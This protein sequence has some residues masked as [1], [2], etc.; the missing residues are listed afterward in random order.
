MHIDNVIVIIIIAEKLWQKCGQKS[1]NKQTVKWEK[2]YANF[3]LLLLQKYLY[4]ARKS[5]LKPGKP[6]VLRYFWG[7]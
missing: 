5:G 2:N 1:S 7:I 3:E 4:K 6:Q